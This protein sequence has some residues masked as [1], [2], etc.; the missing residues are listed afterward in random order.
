LYGREA[1]VALEAIELGLDYLDDAIRR[2]EAPGDVSQ[3]VSGLEIGER[4]LGQAHNPRELATRWVRL[5]S[6]L[7]DVRHEFGIEMAS[8]AAVGADPVERDISRDRLPVLVMTQMAQR[9]PQT[10][11]MFNSHVLRLEQDQSARLLTH[12]AFV[13]FS[14]KRVAANFATLKPGRQKV[15]VDISKRLMWDL[16]QHRDR[17]DSLLPR[18]RHEMILYHPAKDDPTITPRQYNNVMDVVG[19]LEEEG[20]NREIAVLPYVSVPKIADH[21][22]TAEELA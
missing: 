6:S 9:A 14:G 16:E 1:A 13:A 4:V 21:I 11:L 8:V 10:R 19:T 15:A 7:H 17:E 2:G 3:V 18:H 22:L 20:R 5:I 12:K